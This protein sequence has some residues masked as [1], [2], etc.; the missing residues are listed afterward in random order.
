VPSEELDAV[1]AALV[2]GWLERRTPGES[3]RDFCD[4]TSDEELGGIAGREPARRKEAA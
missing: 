2:G 3:F 4:R 1:V